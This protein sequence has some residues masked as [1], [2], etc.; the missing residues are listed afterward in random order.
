[1]LKVCAHKN[2]QTVHPDV[3]RTRI[4]VQK[5]VHTHSTVPSFHR[6]H[7]QEFEH[8]KCNAKPDIL[9]HNA[10]LLWRLPRSEAAFWHSCF[11]L[12][13]LLQACIARSKQ[14]DVVRICG[15]MCILKTHMYPHIQ[16]VEYDAS[17]YF[18]IHMYIRCSGIWC[19]P[20]RAQPARS[21][22]DV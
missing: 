19:S 8:S 18:K 17:S 21:T 22:Q 20:Q 10:A 6:H 12:K 13:V 11:K 5:Y 9:K 2:V 15:Y 7:A 16:I 4:Y 14:Y 3:A 1:M